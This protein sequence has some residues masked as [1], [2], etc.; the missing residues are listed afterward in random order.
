ML[1]RFWLGQTPMWFNV[2]ILGIVFFRLLLIGVMISIDALGLFTES[3]FTIISLIMLPFYVVWGIATWRSAQIY[4]GRKL[5][6]SLT[7]LFVILKCGS[8][9]LA[10]FSG[11][12]F[13][14]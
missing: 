13:L 3:I 9:V 11:F 7:E 8:I 5:W 1:K 10:L 12:S 14:I 6:S 4:K 2:W